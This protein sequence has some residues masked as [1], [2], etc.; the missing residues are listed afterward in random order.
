M[1]EMTEKNRPTGKSEKEKNL[2]AL[3]VLLAGLFMGSLFLDVVQL[4]IGSGFSGRV[5]EKY[6]VLETRGKTWVA[7]TDPKVSLELITE[8]ECATCNADEALVWLRRVLPTLEVRAIEVASPAGQALVERFEITSIPAMVFSGN[9]EQTDF[10]TQAQSL[11]TE[12]DGQYYFR[13]TELGLPAGKYLKQP[14]IAETDIH[15]GNLE[16]PVKIIEYS[17]FQCPYCR[18]FHA[19]LMRALQE[20]MGEVLYVFKNMP[21]SVHPQSLNAALASECAN[22]QG[23]FAAYSDLLF[24]K[25]AE[26][27][28]TAGTRKFKDYAWQLKLDAS[29]FAACLDGKK[30]LSK[31]EQI[32]AEADQFG[33]SGTPATF[34]NNVFL[35]GA[36]SQETINQTLSQALTE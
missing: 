36:V 16:A 22:D 5:A 12:R 23:R 32:R 29:M 33:I 27:G 15:V 20:K 17:D 19:E 24:S 35:K 6:N 31:L 13:M 18:A 1:T 34:V 9:L 8:K 28:N 21:L 2:V 7:Y 14:A 30:H 4:F 25:Q 11:F 10:F 26:W 3:A